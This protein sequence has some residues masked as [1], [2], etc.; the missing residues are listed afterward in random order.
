VQVLP[1]IP[2]GERCREKQTM[3]TSKVF[4]T[5]ILCWVVSVPAQPP[6]TKTGLATPKCVVWE[7]I[8]AAK[9]NNLDRVIDRTDLAEIY[10]G[11]HGRETRDLVD[12]LRGIDLNTAKI[13]GAAWISDPPLEKESI[14]VE[15]ATG[16][17]LRFDFQLVKSKMVL[18]NRPY[19]HHEIPIIPRY[20]L[21]EIHQHP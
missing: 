18:G 2:G 13:Q 3:K 1:R 15:T 17:E 8:R 9:D 11:P 12:F 5:V 7:L 20:E 6:I 10:R 4:L 16:N 14:I 19:S 21:I